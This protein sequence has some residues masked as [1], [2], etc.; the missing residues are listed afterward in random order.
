MQH[1]SITSSGISQEASRAATQAGEDITFV[2]NPCQSHDEEDGPP[3]LELSTALAE[4]SSTDLPP[5]VLSIRDQSMCIS[6][7]KCE[8]HWANV[9][10]IMSSK[11]INNT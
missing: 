4:M 6:E 9:V 1:T 11:C 8:T 3:V 5:P 2:C 7:N 10:L